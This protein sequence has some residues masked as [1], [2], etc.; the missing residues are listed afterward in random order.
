MY[1][2]L[3]QLAVRSCTMARGKGF[4]RPYPSASLHELICTRPRNDSLVLRAARMKLLS[5]VWNISPFLRYAGYMS[6]CWC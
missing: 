5:E 2:L 3:R 4:S 1:Q 6:D